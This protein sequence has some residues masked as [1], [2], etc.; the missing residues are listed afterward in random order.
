MKVSAV[1][2]E[3]NPFHNGHE[4]LLS[5]VRSGGATH[6]AAIMSGNFTQRGEPAIIDKYTRTRTALTGGAD[7]VI[8]LPG[9]FA[10]G[11]AQ[12]FA[13]GGIGI[14]DALGVVDELAFGS[15]CGKTDILHKAAQA[16]DS[17]TFSDALKQYLAKGMTF[18]AAREAAVHELS[19][20]EISAVLANPNDILAVEY[21]RALSELGSS[22]SPKP[23]K[24]LGASHDSMISDS[25]TASASLIRERMINGGDWCSFVPEYAKDIY[26]DSDIPSGG[27]RSKLE[28]AM[29]YRLRSMSVQELS[30]LP[31]VSEGLENRLYSAIKN[32]CSVDN[33]IASVK[34]KRYTHARIRRILLY[35]LLGFTSDGLSKNVQYIRVLGM[36]SRGR[37]ILKAAQN[38]S[39]LPIITRAAEA[40]SLG[41]AASDFA[42]ET[43]CDDIYALTAGKILPCGGN[44]T[45]KMII[46]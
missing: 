7:I 28:T 2:C 38:V 5:A 20:K 13:R 6:I 17:S 24:R 35:A 32:G 42:L 1:I 25:G 3:F 15:E 8:E 10:A 36:N 23:Y 37:E 31:L 19:G 43:K 26:R 18:A 40:A 9:S 27:R 29:L 11:W 16:L 21:I 14:A 34:T 12:R 4:Y 45:E 46:I 22:I 33:I 30:Q 44:C 41:A 39:K